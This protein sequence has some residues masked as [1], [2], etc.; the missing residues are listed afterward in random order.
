[1]GRATPYYAAPLKAVQHLQHNTT[2]Y[3]NVNI[4][5]KNVPNFAYGKIDTSLSLVINHLGQSFS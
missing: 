1:M 2:P 5:Y 3:C 4:F